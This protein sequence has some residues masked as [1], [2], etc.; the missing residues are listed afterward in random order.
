MRRGLF[1]QESKSQ[2]PM[3]NCNIQLVTFKYLTMNSSNTAGNW[4]LP[5]HDN[6]V[7]IPVVAEIFRASE[8]DEQSPYQP[9]APPVEVFT[10]TVS[11]VS[12]WSTAKKLTKSGTLSYMGV[13]KIS[14]K[15]G[16][17]GSAAGGSDEFG[18]STGVPDFRF[19]SLFA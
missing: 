5:S 2:K 8:T 16:G 13:E 14:S 10:T 17:W 19:C 18:I 11:N 15:G 7:E 12:E 1:I 9:P 4:N 3:I 6:R